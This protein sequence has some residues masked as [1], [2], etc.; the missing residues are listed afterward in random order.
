M[1]PTTEVCEAPQTAPREA[2]EATTPAPRG[3]VQPTLSDVLF[4]AIR[5]KDAPLVKVSVSGT[6]EL[7]VAE[8]VALLDG[9]LAAGQEFTLRAAGFV[10]SPGTAWV[11]RS[12]TDE[13][14]GERATWWENEG[15]VKLKITEIGGVHMTGEEW[16]A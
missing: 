8:F 4:P 11:R 9:D 5:R 3:I 6:V 1:N 15:R 2:P 16:S 13:L 12:E 10:L 14:T 7:E